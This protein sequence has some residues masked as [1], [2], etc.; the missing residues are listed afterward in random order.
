MIYACSLELLQFCMLLH[1]IQ[2][3]IFHMKKYLNFSKIPRENSNFTTHLGCPHYVCVRKSEKRP[4]KKTGI[5]SYPWT[6]CPSNFVLLPWKLDNPY[7]HN[8]EILQNRICHSISPWN[9]KS[10]MIWFIWFIWWWWWWCCC[11]SYLMIDQYIKGPWIIWSSTSSISFLINY[12]SSIIN[13]TKTW[14]I[15][16]KH[17]DL[18]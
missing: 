7:Y 5:T 10:W 13:W 11:L 17:E 6:V 15:P 3:K 2:R 18:H 8:G 9:E 1:K 16:K 14:P 12:R 4:G